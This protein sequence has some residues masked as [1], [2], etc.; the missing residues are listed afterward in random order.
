MLLGELKS[1]GGNRFISTYPLRKTG[2]CRHLTRLDDKEYPVG[3]GRLSI[4][5][6]PGPLLIKTGV[7]GG[8]A[9]FK[10]RRESR[11]ISRYG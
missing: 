2:P 8:Y 3:D 7:P 4:T 10:G 1:L 9:K 5:G 11:D 6:V